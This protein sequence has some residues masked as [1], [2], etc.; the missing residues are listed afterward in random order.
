MIMKEK[1]IMA[2]GVL[3]YIGHDLIA[4]CE[5]FRHF[6]SPDIRTSLSQHS[7]AYL[8]RLCLNHIFIAL[9][10]WQEFY[11]RFARYIPAQ[12]KTSAKKLNADLDSRGLR[13][14]RN[15]FLTHIWSRE[16]NRPLT[17]SEISN[18][19][20][21]VAGGDFTQFVNWIHDYHASEKAETVVQIVERLRNAF[22]DVYGL[23]DRDTSPGL[24]KDDT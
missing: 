6:Q 9:S 12:E 16:Q 24:F 1:A 14:F 5:A 18:T 11:K 4:A 19:A 8:N 10:R 23:T 17:D 3:D 7:P 20:R 22:F 13:T 21:K 2:Y 15:E